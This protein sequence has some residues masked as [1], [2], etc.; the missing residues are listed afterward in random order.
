MDNLIE[1]DFL[2]GLNPE[3][4][5][6]RL[7]AR[8]QELETQE[9][10]LTAETDLIIAKAQRMTAE[11]Q[12]SGRTAA[13]SRTRPKKPKGN[14]TNHPIENQNSADAAHSLLDLIGC[15]SEG[16][17]GLYTIA[18]RIEILRQALAFEAGLRADDTATMI[19]RFH[20]SADFEKLATW[21][22]LFQQDDGQ[23]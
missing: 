21:N 15:P 4:K 2:R 19:K 14:M 22:A 3:E 11:K 9:A 8:R 12:L 1:V 6:E 5:I 10:D 7:A 17:D 20:A 16:K 13:K 18:G 23:L